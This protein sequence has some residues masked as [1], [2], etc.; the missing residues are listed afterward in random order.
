MDNTI[1]TLNLSLIQTDNI[2]QQIDANLDHLESKL[3]DLSENSDLILLPEL[4][5]TGFTMDA[6]SVSEGMNGKGVKWM[7]AM[8]AKLGSVLIGS[9]LIEEDGNYYNRLITA[10]P[11]NDILTYDKR[12][13]FSF[14]GEDKVFT[15]G[16]QRLVFEYKGFKICPMI[17]Y[18]LRF[19]VWARNTV[20]FDLLLYVANWPQARISAWDALLRARAIENLCYTAGLNRVGTDANDL[21]Y[22]GHS[23]VYNA[24]GTQIFSLEEGQQANAT[25]SLDLQHIRKT[26]DQ[27]RFLEDR[28]DFEII[29]G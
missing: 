3:H 4:F 27:F 21:T 18:D 22:S 13:L 24:M 8:A 2:W 14:A 20:D 28:D 10:F 25:V 16:T 29:M 7:K 5:T 15:A 12:H 19:P 26:R 1:K 11:N 23:A 9:L 17:C 6:K